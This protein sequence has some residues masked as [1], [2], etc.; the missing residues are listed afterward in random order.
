M[1]A[2]RPARHIKDLLTLRMNS[3]PFQTPRK[4]YATNQPVRKP[5]KVIK[6]IPGNR[7]LGREIAAITATPRTNPGGTTRTE[8]PS[9]IRQAHSRQSS[10]TDKP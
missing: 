7:P 8:Q 1:I 9:R 6:P 2:D 4:N 10:Y 3:T 5:R